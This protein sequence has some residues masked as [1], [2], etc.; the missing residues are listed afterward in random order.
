MR[1]FPDQELG[2]LRDLIGRWILQGRQACLVLAPPLFVASALSQS[3]QPADSVREASVLRGLLAENRRAFLAER[4]QAVDALERVYAQT[5]RRLES[6]A[7]QAGFYPLAIKL[8]DRGRSLQRTIEERDPL[9]LAER[10]T[11][12]VELSPDEAQLSGL[13]I[14]K[15]SRLQRWSSTRSSASWNLRGFEPG[16]YEIVARYSCDDEVTESTNAAGETIL[17]RAGGLI[18]FGERSNLIGG[19]DQWITH[20]VLPTDDWDQFREVALGSLEI[21]STA[22]VLRLEVIEIEAS[23]L[24]H[25]E[26]L[27]LMPDTPAP[28]AETA[29]R[30][31]ED[32]RRAFESA[33]QR[34]SQPF[35]QD[36][37]TRLQ[38]LR[39]RADAASDTLL[40]D[41]IDAAL[42]TVRAKLRP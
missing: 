42:A 22:P 36:Q 7:A 38:T 34:K 5:L 30:S 13:V 35:H 41:R 16:R 40:R 24:M 29:S 14:R 4:G 11:A 12:A 26:S 8:R 9:K 15:N 18:T 2:H 1:L 33:Q 19:R 6:E 32:L 37:L 21:N 25:L 28:S 31:L 39:E 10:Q 3:P 20:R 17:S 23:G 27:R